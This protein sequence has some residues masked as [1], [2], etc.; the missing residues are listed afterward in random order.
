MTSADPLPLSSCPG[1]GPIAPNPANRREFLKRAGN[2][3]GRLA[4]S[5]MLNAQN[6]ARAASTSPAD[7]ASSGSNT[8]PAP[9]SFRMS[10]CHPP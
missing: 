2:G 10:A 6:Q 3:F 5:T 4:A 1:P 9:V 8:S 7:V